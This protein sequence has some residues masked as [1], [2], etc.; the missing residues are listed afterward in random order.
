MEKGG[1]VAHHQTKQENKEAGDGEHED[2]LQA[3]EEEGTTTN[4]R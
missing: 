1:R 3:A 2:R 4:G